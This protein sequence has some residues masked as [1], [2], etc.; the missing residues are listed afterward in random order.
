MRVLIADADLVVHARLLQVD[1]LVSTEGR[2]S[3]ERQALSV[4]VLGV[5]KGPAKPGDRLRFAQHGHGAPRYRTG[6]EVLLFLR[7]LS[8]SRELRGLASTHGLRWYSSQEQNDAYILAP[9]AREAT[10]A[11]AGTYAAIEAMPPDRRTEALHKITVKLLRS[12]D[13]R[14]SRSALRDLAAQ[15][16]APLV[17]IRDVPGLLR[18]IDDVQRPIQLRVGLLIELDRRGLV[19]SESRW[20]RWLRTTR[21][22]DRLPVIEAAGL[23]ASSAVSEEL[24][25]ILKGPDVALGAAAAVALGSPGHDEAVEPLSEALV[26]GEA[27]LAMAAIRGL[28]NIG[29]PEATRALRTAAESHS[30]SKVRRRAQA[31]LRLLDSRRIR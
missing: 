6:D 1:E 19:E 2:D 5:I 21:G 16:G 23:Q 15:P 11:A 17:T 29:T 26:S 31:E 4:Q 12:K 3:W 10:V 18:V 25:R 8:R 9:S 24:V 28:G 14:L 13:P 7:K 20:V 22:T 27:R 30:D